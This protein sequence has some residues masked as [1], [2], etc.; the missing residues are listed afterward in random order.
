MPILKFVDPK[1]R[2]PTILQLQDLTSNTWLASRNNL[3]AICW[4]CN[5]A[6]SLDC[7]Q[8][9]K[10]EN[11]DTD[12][13]EGK[14]IRL[15]GRQM[16]RRKSQPV[17][18]KKILNLWLLIEITQEMMQIQVC[19]AQQ[20]TISDLKELQVSMLSF[21]QDVSTDGLALELVFDTADQ[22]NPEYP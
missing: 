5:Q 7:E 6:E 1:A 14:Q 2:K 22:G 10:P 20:W 11:Y 4:T 13:I 15:S 21:L 16:G 19:V 12:C 3:P 18:N 17:E 8:F 9:N